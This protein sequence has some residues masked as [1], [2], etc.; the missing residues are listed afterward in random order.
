MKIAYND[1][2]LRSLVFLVEAGYD[3]IPNENTLGNELHFFD[4]SDAKGI[5]G[6]VS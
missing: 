2:S 4:Q 1:K 5:L 3:K 6:N